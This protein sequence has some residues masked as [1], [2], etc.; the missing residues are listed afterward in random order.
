M[1]VSVLHTLPLPGPFLKESLYIIEIISWKPKDELKASKHLIYHRLQVVS[2]L[3]RNCEDNCLQRKGK[4]GHVLN[5]HL[6]PTVPSCLSS[7]QLQKPPQQRPWRLLS[8]RQNEVQMPCYI[9]KN[10]MSSL[11]CS[12]LYGSQI[13]L[14]LVD[15][16]FSFCPSQDKS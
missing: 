7:A 4:Q 10:L 5:A 1:N 12:W 15:F 9:G 8:G 16:N 14:S 13:Y 6:V 2:L 3:H 11:F